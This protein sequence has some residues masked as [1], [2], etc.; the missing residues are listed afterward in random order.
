[1]SAASLLQERKFTAEVLGVTHA[2]AADKA[3]GAHVKLGIPTVILTTIVA[4]SAFA[5]LTQIGKTQIIIG[6]FCGFLSL[7]AAVL[8]ALQTFL[9]FKKKAQ[10][11]K[12]A[13]DRFHAFARAC[14]AA[15]AAEKNNPTS[16][17]KKL[18]AELDK[19]VQESPRVST[20]AQEEV[21]RELRN[22]NSAAVSEVAKTEP[23][24]SIKVGGF[25]GRYIPLD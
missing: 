17:L 20:K 12:K 3:E 1:M 2:K 25:G 11:H 15:L 6:V 24:E 18:D 19:I 9:D 13:A 4:G 22:E 21:A 14:A 7:S 5:N 8:S 16:D 10:A 23:S